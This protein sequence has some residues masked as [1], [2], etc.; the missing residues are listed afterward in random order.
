[1]ASE[2]VVPELRMGIRYEMPAGDDGADQMTVREAILRRL[3][4]VGVVVQDEVPPRVG[5][6]LTFVLDTGEGP[7]RFG[8]HVIVRL[9]GPGGAP[10]GFGAQIASLDT[11]TAGRLLALRMTAGSMA[12]D[13]PQ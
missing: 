6:R 4:S 7:L 8:G 9:R 11:A 12:G 5:E 10:W 1:M 3:G 2:A 13:R